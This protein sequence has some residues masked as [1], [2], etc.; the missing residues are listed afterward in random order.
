MTRPCFSSCFGLPL[1]TTVIIVGIIELV[2]TII[3]TFLNVV[4][5]TRK[6]DT[7]GEEC[8]GKDICIGPLIKYSVFDASFGVLLAFCL[9]F[10]GYLR[11]HCL[12]V[13]WMIFTVIASLKYI[14]VVV[15]HDW[16]SL[17]VSNLSTD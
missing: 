15:T 1:Q 6:I 4:K 3:A 8:K 10:G 9:I 16:T 13:T 2:I 14:W 7:E 11:N 5:L 12:L 17:E